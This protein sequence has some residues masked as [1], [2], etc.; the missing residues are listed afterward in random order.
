MGTI[1]LSHEPRRSAFFEGGEDSRRGSRRGGTPR[2]RPGCRPSQFFSWRSR[3]RR[4]RSRRST[5]S[6]TRR[7]RRTS[8]TSR[9]ASRLPP[10]RV[11]R[12]PWFRAAPDARRRRHSARGALVHPRGAA[13]RANLAARDELAVLTRDAQSRALTTRSARCRLSL[14]LSLSPWCPPRP[15][16]RSAREVLCGI[17]SSS[18]GSRHPS[19]FATRARRAASATDRSRASAVG[20]YCVLTP[21]PD[22]RPRRPR[23]NVPVPVPAL[24]PASRVECGVL[25]KTSCAVKPD[26]EDLC[27]FCV[28]ADGAR[29]CCDDAC[30]EYDDCCEDVGGC[31]AVRRP[32]ETR[33]DAANARRPHVKIEGEDGMTPTDRGRGVVE[34]RRTRKRSG[35]IDSSLAT[36]ESSPRVSSRPSRRSRDQISSLSMKQHAIRGRDTLGVAR[37]VR[38]DQKWMGSRRWRAP[39]PSPPR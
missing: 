2:R 16:R 23:D 30:G 12:P 37:R 7:G 35:E 28:F 33:K 13:A 8:P 3:S 22:K 26:G 15:R 31:C 34:T 21:P 27:G 24:V 32:S 25:P 38:L 11:S 5:P 9:R 6:R 19:A 36:R 14:S 10:T 39:L 1:Q 29:C 17:H 20:L 18:A 4:R